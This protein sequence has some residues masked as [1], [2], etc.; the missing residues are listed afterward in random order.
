M[1]EFSN[2]NKNEFS[3]DSIFGRDFDNSVSE[4]SSEMSS[5]NSSDG[6]KCCSRSEI[7]L[8]DDVMFN[9]MPLH[10][11]IKKTYQRKCDE[12]VNGQIAV[13]MYQ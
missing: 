10:G 13:E 5:A 8:V 9:L 12:A 3:N 7:L 11:I 1:A 4:A 2:N 6:E